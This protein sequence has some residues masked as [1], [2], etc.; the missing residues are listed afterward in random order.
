MTLP[1][2]RTLDEAMA[3]IKAEDPH[4]AITRHFLWSAV[5]SGRLPSIKAGGKYLINLETL[6]QFL[7]AP[8]EGNT[9]TNGIYRIGG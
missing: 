5:R 9:P 7:S 1:K 2:M 8:S 6:S 3:E 4:T